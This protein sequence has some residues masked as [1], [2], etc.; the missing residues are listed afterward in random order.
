MKERWLLMIWMRVNWVSWL[1]IWN[2]FWFNLDISFDWEWKKKCT[3]AWKGRGVETA[4]KSVVSRKWTLLLCIGCFCAG[5]LFSDRYSFPYFID[6]LIWS[7]NF[8]CL[9]FGEM[10]SCL[11]PNF[12]NFGFFWVSGDGFWWR[13]LE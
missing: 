2:G 8:V 3:M 12:Q 4:S 6:L 13:S 11:S 7:S 9:Q 10:G 5:M 1:G